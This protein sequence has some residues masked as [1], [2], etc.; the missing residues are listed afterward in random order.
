MQPKRAQPVVM[1]LLQTCS[2][3]IIARSPQVYIPPCPVYRYLSHTYVGAI[4]RKLKS[5]VGL[6]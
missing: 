2:Y 6:N 4:M 3:D 5:W 1:T